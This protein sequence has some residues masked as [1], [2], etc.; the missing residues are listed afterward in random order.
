[1]AHGVQTND[2]TTHTRSPGILRRTAR[3][4]GDFFDP[5]LTCNECGFEDSQRRFA[6]TGAAHEYTTGAGWFRATTT[7]I[8]FRCPRCDASQFV[9]DVRSYYPLF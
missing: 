5:P 7:E 2:R 3:A 4:I 1:M 9:H 6:K 8:E